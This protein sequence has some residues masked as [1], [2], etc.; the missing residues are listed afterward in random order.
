MAPPTNFGKML[1]AFEA[2]SDHFRGRVD[3]LERRVA[4]EYVRP[5][6]KGVAARPRGSVLAQGACL[7][8]P[9]PS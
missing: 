7:L 2:F 1:E 6:A 4:V 9:C 3:R 5:V 8:P